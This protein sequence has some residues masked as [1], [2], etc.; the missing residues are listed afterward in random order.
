MSE[1]VE[2]TLGGN[3]AVLIRGGG[4]SVVTDP[5][6]SDRIGP[7]PRLRPAALNASHLA[8]LNAILISHV[9]PD[10]LDLASL[11]L[12]PKGTPVLTPGGSPYRKLRGAGHACHVLREWEEWRSGELRVVAVPSVHTRWCLG[13]VVEAG[14]RRVYFAGDAGPLTPFEEIDRRC[15]PLDVALMP[16]GGSSLAV[17]RLQRHLTPELA[18]RATALLRPRVVIPI[19]WGHMRCVPTALD[20]FR[21]TADDFLRLMSS[22]AGD[23]QVLSPSEGIPLAI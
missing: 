14:G 5:W 8:G 2:I 7:W 22:Q 13:Y 1:R 18:A 16:V 19:H 17:G 6:L 9:H 15:G 12:A 10:H 4:A 3:A 21:G 11:A 23:I 20:R